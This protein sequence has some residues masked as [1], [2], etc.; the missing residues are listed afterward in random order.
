MTTARERAITT[1][2]RETSLDREDPR[3]I[4]ELLERHG[5]V[6][7]DRAQLQ[8]VLA[9][10][11]RQT[12]EARKR[13]ACEMKLG[14]DYYRRWL[15]CAEG[16]QDERDMVQ[17][18]KRIIAGLRRAVVVL[19]ADLLCAVAPHVGHGMVWR[20]LALSRRADAIRAA[21]RRGEYRR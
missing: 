8:R 1:L 11:R 13:I 3:L 12:R 10:S 2:L 21:A 14:T 19:K 9:A 17:R 15:S 7:V 18:Q 6:V 5:F 4:V 16:W 20:A